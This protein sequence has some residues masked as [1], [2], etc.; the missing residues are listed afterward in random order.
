MTLMS[1]PYFIPDCAVKKEMFLFSY[2]NVFAYYFTLLV[3]TGY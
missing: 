1:C 3:F 2:Q